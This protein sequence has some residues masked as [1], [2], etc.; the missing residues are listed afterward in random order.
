MAMSDASNERRAAGAASAPRRAAHGHMGAHCNA[1]VATTSLVGELPGCVWP[2]P[3]V[4]QRIATH[5]R[6][7]RASTS[8]MPASRIRIPFS[9]FYVSSFWHFRKKNKFVV[10]G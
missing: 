5:C 2:Q 10:Y 1:G 9:V 8:T 4:A 6:L 3:R 7:L